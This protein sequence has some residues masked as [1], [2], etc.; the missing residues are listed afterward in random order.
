[1]PKISMTLNSKSIDSALKEVKRYREKVSS[2]GA[3]IV[4]IA[5]EKGAETAKEMVLYMNAY[6]SGELHDGIIGEAN[7]KTGFIISTAPHSAYV[8]MGT[9]V[10]GAGS[11]NPNNTVPGWEYDVNEHGEYGWWYIGKD[12]RRH[13]TKGMPSR[14]FMYETA[15]QLRQS[16]PYIVEEALKD[17]GK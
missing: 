15:E 14:P 11:P 6:D 13:W 3:E 8:E 16:V 9:G 1:M 12:G 17:G 4:K 10:V 2:L 7:G 5:T